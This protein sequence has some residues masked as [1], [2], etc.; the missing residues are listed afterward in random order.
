M[1]LTQTNKK[2]NTQGERKRELTLLSLP[3]AFLH[4]TFDLNL[5]SSSPPFY[6]S[7]YEPLHAYDLC[8]V[9]FLLSSFA[10]QNKIILLQVGRK[11][12]A[13]VSFL[14]PFAFKKKGYRFENPLEVKKLN[15]PAVLLCLC[16]CACVCL[17]VCMRVLI[18]S[19]CENVTIVPLHGE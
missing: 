6:F 7:L 2:K 19:L 17:F 3:Q 9:G 8:H 10:K 12:Y 1:L 16:V 13:A 11:V 14:V 5:A 18:I 4:P 15:E